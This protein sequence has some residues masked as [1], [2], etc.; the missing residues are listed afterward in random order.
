MWPDVMAR[1][2]GSKRTTWSLVSHYAQVLDYDGKRL[3]LQFDSPGRAA[4]FSRGAHQEFL[5]QA[6]IDVLGIDC[7]F[8]AVAG[9][10][11]E[12][13]AQVAPVRARPGSPDAAA[14]E[15][16]A[17][18]AASVEAAR[19][20][21]TRRSVVQ[22]A[23]DDDIPLPPEPPP[24]DVPPEDTRPARPRRAAA[25]PAPRATSASAGSAL[26]PAAIRLGDDVPSVDDVDLEGSNLVGASVVEQLLGGRVIE[27]RPD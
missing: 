8:E 3:L 5:R 22:L 27:E 7:T 26:P 12:Q 15:P 9:D 4:S 2:S 6:L 21:S 17:E 16:R 14:P 20:P 11:R 24:D 13:R 1:L 25:P 23:S 18:A 10:V 19:A